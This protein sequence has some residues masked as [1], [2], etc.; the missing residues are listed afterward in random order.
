MIIDDEYLNPDGTMPEWAEQF[1]RCSKWIEDALKYS[2]GTHSIYDILDAVA[3]NQMQLW[4]G[5]KSAVITEI[6]VHPQ[7]KMLHLALAGGNLEELSVMAHSIHA[8][9]KHIEADGITIAGRRGWARTFM[10][11]WNFKPLYYWMHM[12]I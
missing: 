4:P 11:D 10:R 7:K 3:C 6:V 9:A 1:V 5:E 12:E 8:F 2:A